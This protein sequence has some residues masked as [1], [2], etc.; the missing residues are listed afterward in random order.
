M[1]T[2]HNDR[3]QPLLR[4]P[5]NQTPVTITLEGGERASAMLFVQPGTSVKRLLAD[6]TP[7]VP[8][9]FTEGTRLVARAS[10]VCITVHVLHAHVEDHEELCERQKSLVRLRGGQLMRGELRWMPESENR[11]TLDH[12][13][14]QSS[15]LTVHDGDHVSYIAK[16]HVASVEDI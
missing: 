12:L 1:A 11:R 9:A 15:H 13:N 7:F 5:R 4:I 16:S 14:D 6:S 10:I 3:S 2:T 8:V